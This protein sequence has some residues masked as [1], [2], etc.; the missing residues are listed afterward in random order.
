MIIR[1][2][3]NN[4]TVAHNKSHYNPSCFAYATKHTRLCIAN[5]FLSINLD[6]LSQVSYNETY[7]TKL[8]LCTS[9]IQSLYSNSS[10]TLYC[11]VTVLNYIIIHQSLLVT[12]SIPCSTSSSTISIGLATNSFSVIP[13]TS[14]RMTSSNTSKLAS[15]MFWG[16]H[17]SSVT[18]TRTHV[19]YRFTML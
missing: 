14:V 9:E 12:S 2:L 16:A 19:T 6:Y 5:S 13:S 8:N 15:S 1:K 18:T 7:L 10:L 11:S 4:N 17:G 3:P